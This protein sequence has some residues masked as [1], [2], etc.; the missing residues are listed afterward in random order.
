MPG[1]IDSHS[2]GRAL[3][4][5]ILG[6]RLGSLE[7]FLTCFPFLTPLD[8]EDDAFVAGS[9]LL[10]TGVTSV[11]VIYHSFAGPDLYADAAR[12][13]A[14]GLR[15][16]GI[17]FELVLGMTDQHEYLPPGVTLPTPPPSPTALALVSP[18]RGLDAAGHLA[19]FDQ[20]AATREHWLG[21][22][23]GLAIGPVAPQWCSDSLLAGIALR[24]ASGARVHTHLLEAAHQRSAYEEHPLSRLDRFQLLG[25]ALSAAHTV[26]V[27]DPEIARL[28][29]TGAVIVH[30]PGSN[31]RLAT[32]IAPVPRALAC[33]VTIGF[34]LDSNSLTYPPDVFVDL[35]E[36]QRASAALGSPL[37][38]RD[39]LSLATTGSA[40]ALGLRRRVGELHPGACADFV[41]L[42][43]PAALSAEDPL[44]AIV[45]GG[46][47]DAVREV[48]VGGREV[49][50]IG[51]D[52][53]GV[54]AARHRL[55]SA[56]V[57]DSS[58][59]GRLQQLTELDEWLD[60]AWDSV[61]ASSKENRR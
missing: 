50:S 15:K 46:T 31:I 55:V 45:T 7:R 56:V 37:A 13:V 5:E 21:A 54:K 47:R 43:L 57:A 36:A 14:R 60:A 33:G 10:S 34:G 22:D 27:G 12:S 44:E 42:A 19:L 51:R 17:R 53:R 8:A 26:W 35:R 20:L 41:K 9:D 25:P 52:R 30:C 40:A 39:L 28:A 38:A 59:A 18:E 6:G 11:Q 2:H 61:L 1:L 58:L 16:S 24:A 49:H 23:A 3:P 48:F 32:G 29:D 4:A